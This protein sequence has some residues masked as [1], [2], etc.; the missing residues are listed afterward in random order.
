MAILTRNR[1]VSCEI[2]S[3]VVY[4][5]ID[6]KAVGLNLLLLVFLFIVVDWILLL[7]LLNVS[8]DAHSILNN[9]SL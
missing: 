3:I 6:N 2:Y 1:L 4:Y 9:L 5:F 8:W 7:L